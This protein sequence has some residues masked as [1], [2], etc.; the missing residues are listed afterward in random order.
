M[1]AAAAVAVGHKR[2]IDRINNEKM[3]TFGETVRLIL[4]QPRRPMIHPSQ[5]VAKNFEKENEVNIFHP[6][7]ILYFPLL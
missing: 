1:Q 6:S 4:D 2:Y 7:T 5:W 3:E